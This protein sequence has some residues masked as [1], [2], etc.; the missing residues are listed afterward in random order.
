[1]IYTPQNEQE[2]EIVIRLIRG[3]YNY[4]TGKTLP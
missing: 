2:L 4:I 1:M 3:S